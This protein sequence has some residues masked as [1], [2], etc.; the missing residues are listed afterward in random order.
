[1][2]LASSCLRIVQEN[3]AF[4]THTP[5]LELFAKYLS[6]IILKFQIAHKQFIVIMQDLKKKPKKTQQTK[7]K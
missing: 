1:M 7:Q 6:Q 3:L 4:F 2:N 5:Y